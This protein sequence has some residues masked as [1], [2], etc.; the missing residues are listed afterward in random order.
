MQAATQ[1]IVLDALHLSILLL[2]VG[3]PAYALIRHFMPLLQWERRGNVWTSPFHGTDI[4]AVALLAFAARTMIV[5]SAKAGPEQKYTA[6]LVLSASLVFLVLA[7]ALVLMMAYRRVNLLELFGLD[8]IEPWPLVW[9]SALIAA[10]AVVAVNGITTLLAGHVLSPAWRDAGDQEMV[11][12]L[13]QSPDKALRLAIVVTA[14]VFQPVAEEVIFRGYVY[15]AVKRFTERW[16]AACFSALLFATLHQHALA[17]VPLFV[18]GLI[19][20]ASYEWT[21]S[22]WVPVAVHAFFNTTTVVGQL[23][24]PGQ[25]S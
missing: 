7:G 12:L 17:L 23:F 6:G 22:I 9:K 18:F 16:F 15:P 4:L 19:L 14:C 2:A 1:A 10:F 5:G 24:F 11:R 8:R 20:V 3:L 21:G 25:G 13:R